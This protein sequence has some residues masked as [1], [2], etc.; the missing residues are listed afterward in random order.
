MKHL[1]NFHGRANRAEFW[2]VNLIILVIG[3]VLQL[4]ALGLLGNTSAQTQGQFENLL[5]AFSAVTAL[6]LLAL[7]SRRL[8][9]I[10]KSGWWQLLMLTGVGLIPLT[11]WFL[12]DGQAQENTYGP[13]TD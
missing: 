8:H 13:P 12:K 3:L 9:D 11:I 4:I 1:I 10:G 6:P 7:G 5:T 2:K